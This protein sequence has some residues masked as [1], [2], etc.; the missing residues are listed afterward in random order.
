MKDIDKFKEDIQNILEKFQ[1][2]GETRRKFFSLLVEYAEEQQA[3]NPK[4]GN[5]DD[6]NQQ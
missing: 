5:Q 3:G 4:K 6:H 1:F 2:D